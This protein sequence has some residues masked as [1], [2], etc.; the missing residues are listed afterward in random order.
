MFDTGVANLMLDILAQMQCGG[1]GGPEGAGA[2]SLLLVGLL[3][4][5][6]YLNPFAAV[7]QEQLGCTTTACNSTCSDCISSLFC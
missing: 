7:L 2:A 6:S 5:V 3:E 4:W 1:G